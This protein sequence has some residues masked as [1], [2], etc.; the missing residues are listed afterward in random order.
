MPNVAIAVGRKL[1]ATTGSIRGRRG[2]AHQRHPSFI[3]G[4]KFLIDSSKRLPERFFDPH[5]GSSH[6]LDHRGPLVAVEDVSGH[7]RFDTA[8][9]FALKRLPREFAAEGG[10]DPVFLRVELVVYERVFLA[11]PPVDVNFSTA[12]SP[13]S[14]E[15]KPH[16]ANTRARAN[17]ALAARRNVLKK[18]RFARHSADDNQQ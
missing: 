18:G 10:L 17:P 11:V 4:P 15:V 3:S 7:L 6:K 16:T 9:S 1:L 2:R 12:K 14:D 5:H 13:A 8:G